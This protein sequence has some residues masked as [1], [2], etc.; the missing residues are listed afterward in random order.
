VL[1][2]LTVAANNLSQIQIICQSASL[3]ALADLREIP[4]EEAAQGS[5][6]SALQR[7]IKPYGNGNKEIR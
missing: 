4:G 6:Q 5:V 3:K 2:F 1:L 7:S